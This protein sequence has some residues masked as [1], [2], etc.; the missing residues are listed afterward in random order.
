VRGVRGWALVMENAESGS[1]VGVG[2][3]AGVIC[4]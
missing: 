3:D 2:S 4:E 1:F